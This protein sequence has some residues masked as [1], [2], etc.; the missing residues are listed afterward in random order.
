[1]AKAALSQRKHDLQRVAHLYRHSEPY[2]PDV[3]VYCG[4]TATS[5]DH[6]TPIWHVARLL[7]IIEHHRLRLRHGLYTVPSCRDCNSRLGGFIAF[8]I[9]EKRA[10]LKRRLRTKH[11]RLLQSYDWHPEEISE[12]GPTLRGFLQRQEGAR[13]VLLDRLAFPRA[14]EATSLRYRAGD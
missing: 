11:Q 10:E 4:E 2:G 7:D 12:H 8:S 14:W 5:I 6:V 13:N 3:C 1:M 9:T